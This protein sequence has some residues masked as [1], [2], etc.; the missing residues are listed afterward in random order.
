DDKF[1]AR[2]P[3]CEG[4]IWWSSV[5]RALDE[6]RFFGLR[7]K[8]VAHLE[9]SAELYV[10][11]AFAGADPRHRIGVRVVSE[12]AP[13]ALF[14]KTLFI[15]PAEEELDDFEPEALVLHAPSLEALPAEDGTRTAT[16]VVLHPSRP[17]VLIG[18]PF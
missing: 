12:R 17:Q 14:A 11:D 7:D 3:G 13:H 6:E 9:Q 5:N 16:F 18:A 4:R 15:E 1:V 8:V 2:E 10:I